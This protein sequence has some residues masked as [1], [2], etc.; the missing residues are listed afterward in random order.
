MFRSLS[1]VFWLVDCV[2]FILIDVFDFVV[3]SVCWMLFEVSWVL[4]KLVLNFLVLFVMLM[5]CKR[6]D[7]FVV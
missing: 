6:M 7:I 1:R 5:V 4:L 2:E 3:C